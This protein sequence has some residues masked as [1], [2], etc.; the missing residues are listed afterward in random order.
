MDSVNQVPIKAFVCLLLYITLTEM[1][2]ECLLRLVVGMLE[3]L[4]I[5]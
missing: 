1:C 5:L 3:A 4:V 2:T